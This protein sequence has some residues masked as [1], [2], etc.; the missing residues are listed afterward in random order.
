LPLLTLGLIYLIQPPAS[1]GLGMML[2]AVCP[3]GSVSN[4]MVH[5]SKGNTALSV[6]LTS[7][8]TLGAIIITPLAFGLWITL[9]P[10]TEALDAAIQVDPERMIKAVIQL[11]L[12]PISLGMFVNYRFPITTARVQRWIK[13]SSMLIFLG[14]VLFA[15]LANVKN[16]YSYLH[17]VFYIV[18]IHNGLSLILGYWF[19]RL[20]GLPEY[21]ARAISIETGIQNSG[22]GLLLVFNFFNG[23][24]GMAL[25]LAWWGV[26][27]LISG[28]CL[29]LYWGWRSSNVAAG[30]LETERVRPEN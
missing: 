7:I 16:M 22:L 25:I 27:H 13:L 1:I 9:V 24:G 15:V 6:M 29:S 21:D 26:W 30:K 17:L 12:V 11:I 14:F 20:N 10:K 18:L 3:G 28:Y 2:L 23:I 4:F 5:L 19:A 8:T